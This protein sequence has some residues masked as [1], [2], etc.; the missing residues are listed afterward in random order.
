VQFD[1]DPRPDYI[2][3]VMGTNDSSLIMFTNNVGKK[4]FAESQA[5]KPENSKWRWVHYSTEVDS[6]ALIMLTLYSLFGDFLLILRL[7]K[8]VAFTFIARKILQICYV[9]NMETNMKLK[10]M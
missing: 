10:C 1:V 3:H 2:S 9:P 4:G 8:D 6:L 7:F 5:Q